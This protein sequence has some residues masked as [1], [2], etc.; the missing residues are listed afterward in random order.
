MNYLIDHVQVT[1]KDLKNAEIFYDALCEAL[2]FDLSKKVHAYLPE[3]NMEVIEYLSDAY[4]FGICSPL[5]EYKEELI[6]RRKPGAVHH[7]AFR[8][9]T[10]EAVDAIYDLLRSL[11]AEIIDPPQVHLSHGP[12]Y[13]ALFF[14]DPDGI[15]YE[16]VCNR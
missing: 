16:I 4:D 1:V 2:G 9:A 10:R 8:A 13:Y 7:V 11:K 14:K 6:H 12:N 15:K 5:P 3:L